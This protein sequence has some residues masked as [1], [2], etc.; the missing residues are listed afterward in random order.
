MQSWYAAWMDHSNKH[1]ELL[2]EAERERLFNRLRTALQA[3]PGSK[4]E[5]ANDTRGAQL[6]TDRLRPAER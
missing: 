3:A 4:R 6:V 5:Q 2:K 1:R